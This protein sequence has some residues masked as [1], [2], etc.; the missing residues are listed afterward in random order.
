VVV[1]ATLCFGVDDQHPTAAV[2]LLF[3]SAACNRKWIIYAQQDV[4]EICAVGAVDSVL[5]A[6][7]AVDSICICR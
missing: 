4:D 3:E 1:L 6:M 2:T 7:G 5:C